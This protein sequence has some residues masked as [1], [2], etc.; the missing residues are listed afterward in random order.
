MDFNKL[1]ERR[2]SNAAKWDESVLKHR[3]GHSD[4]LPFWVA[5]MDLPS[6]PAVSRILHEKADHRIY[7]Y[8]ASNSPFLKAWKK[9]TKEKHSWDVSLS[10]TIFIPGIVSSMSLGVSLFSRPGEGVILQEPV[11]QPFRRI[12]ERNNRVPLVNELVY[13]G[14][15]YTMDFADLEEKA[16]RK[17]T[18]LLLLCSPHNP[19]GRVWTRTELEK[20]DRICRA[21]GVFVISDEIH[22]D[23]VLDSSIR[24]IPYS[25]LSPETAEQSMTCMAPSKTFN[26]AGEKLSVSVIENREKRLLMKNELARLNMNEGSAL[27]LSMGEGAYKEG[28]EWLGKLTDYLSENVK[29]IETYLQKNHPA[30]RMMHPQAG[31]IGWID[32]RDSGYSVE[33][34]EERFLKIGKIALV[35]G[36]WFGTGGHPFFRLNYGCPRSLL[37]EGMKRLSASLTDNLIH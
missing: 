26:I 23:L 36:R 17:E 19:G 7:G 13:D 18:T 1:I 33:E 4:L 32:F 20:V 21:H 15:V 2:N 11:Y 12:I 8:P 34:L 30:I 10:Q 37:E 24:H 14:T 25:S 5:D 9:W 22:C 28:M 27:A 29:Y 16:S 35:E 31:F 6:P 3:F